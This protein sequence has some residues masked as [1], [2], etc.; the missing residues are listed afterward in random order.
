[1][2]ICTSV[3][4]FAFSRSLLASFVVFLWNAASC[5]FPPP[6]ASGWLALPSLFVSISPPNCVYAVSPLL[7]PH[8]PRSLLQ[9]FDSILRTFYS[10]IDRSAYWTLRRFFR[11]VYIWGRRGR[12]AMACI[13]STRIDLI[14]AHQPPIMHKQHKE[15]RG[16]FHVLCLRA[17]VL[18]PTL[19]EDVVRHHPERLLAR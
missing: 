5:A 16:N 19:V 12:D 15:K 3:V 13:S 14:L 2:C 7:P 17:P 18:E 8:I 6:Q 4:A 9:F 1:M 10:F 11:F